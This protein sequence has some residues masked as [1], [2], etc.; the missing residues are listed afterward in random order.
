MF[1]FSGIHNLLQLVI[2]SIA[3]LLTFYFSGT[4]TAFLT[5]NRVRVELWR[6]QKRTFSTIIARFIQSPDRFIY[7]TLVGNNI[8]NVAFASYATVYLNQYF[9]RETTWLL[10]TVITVMIGEIIPKTLFRSLA[11]WVIPK[12]APVLNF[13]YYFF[14]PS[15]WVVN[16]ISRVLLRIFRYE[17]AEITEF[18]TKKDI[19]ILLSESRGRMSL[20][21]NESEI[22]GRLIMLRRLKVRDA[23]IPRTE[24]V[25]IPETASME[26]LAKV[27]DSSGH[28]KIPVYQDNLDRIIGIVL[29]KDLF[30]FP[31]TV[32]EMI[33]PVMFVPDS[34]LSL[35]MLTEFRNKNST[36]AVVIDEYGGTAGLVTVED[37]VEELVGDIVDEFDEK[38]TLIRKV[39]TNTYSVNGR[40]ELEDFKE[41][42]GLE[43]PEGEYDTLA[44]FILNFLGHIPHRDE[45]FE[46]E[47][48]SFVVTRATRRKIEWVRVTIP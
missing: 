15:I 9:G 46:Y 2:I 38:T 10:V 37:L 24:I 31:R 12:V 30:L 25:A 44:G 21:Q 23:M 4:E 36:I 8:A 29:L 48:V 5:V 34:K 6:R 13:F 18:F 47:G 17:S 45:S 22:L 14:L 1:N 40:I 28:T 20:D 16:K 27:F 7:T 42:L 11:D 33:R 32:Q 43:L 35:R 26:H 19:E 3:L 39:D 41:I